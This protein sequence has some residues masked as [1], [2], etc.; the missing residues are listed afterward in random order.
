MRLDARINPFVPPSRESQ[1]AILK[2]SQGAGLVTVNRPEDYVKELKVER[3][4]S[5]H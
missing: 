4:F 5:S 3:G 1:E 2:E